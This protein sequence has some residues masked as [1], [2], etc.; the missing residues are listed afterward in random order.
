MK[1]RFFMF[2]A[3]LL[4][5]A[6]FAKQKEQMY[7]EIRIYRYNSPSQ[8][9]IIDNYLKDAFIP[10]LHRAG[11]K[12]IGVF[13]PVEQDTAYGKMTYVLI[14]YTK[15]EQYFAVVDKLEKDKDYQVSGKEFLDAPYNQPP[16]NRY[17][18]IFMKAFAMMPE[19]KVYSYNTP[20]SE[21][22]YELRSYE[23]AT[24]AKALK[25]IQMFNEGGE[26]KIFEAIGSN[27]VFYGQVLFGSLKPRLM[28]MT[29]YENMKSHDEK[30]A[31]F[32][33]HPEWKRLSSLEEY[34]NTTS[35]TNS[36]LLHPSAYSDF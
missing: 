33:S 16:F 36:Y 20:P 23:S 21:R 28:Y 35:K 2:P 26:M 25:K 31:A 13:K 19:M 1:L 12:N 27:A 15:S 29:T 22:I 11:L 34:R 9:Q 24:D 7:Y 5:L 8:D 14:P 3:I 30:W 32:R 17:E 18:S 4:L 6:G 10:G